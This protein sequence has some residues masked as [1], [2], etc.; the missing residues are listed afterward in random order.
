MYQLKA[1]TYEYTK[2]NFEDWV[3]L[4]V[5]TGGVVD[6]KTNGLAQIYLSYWLNRQLPQNNL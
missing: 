6:F 1:N 4:A 5:N 2:F 3:W